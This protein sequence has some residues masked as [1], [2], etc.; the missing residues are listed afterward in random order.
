LFEVD[1]V[2]ELANELRTLLMDGARRQRFAELSSAKMQQF[3]YA[4]AVET[5]ESIYDSVLSSACPA[6][7]QPSPHSG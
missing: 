2:A 7:R 1:N 4:K 3:T 6:R 5:L